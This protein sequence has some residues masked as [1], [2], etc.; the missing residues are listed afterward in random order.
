MPRRKPEEPKR[1]VSLHIGFSFASAWEGV[2]L[3]WF[4][5]VGL[6]SLTNNATVAVATPFP[7]GVAFLRSNLFEHEIPLLDVQF[8]THARL[9]ELLLA[10]DDSALPLRE[11]L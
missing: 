6:A 8:V 5:E 11:P 4:K 3:P 10:D 1:S 7:S 9:R 2:L